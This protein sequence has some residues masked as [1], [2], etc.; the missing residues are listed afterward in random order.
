MAISI[1]STPSWKVAA[2]AA[3]TN[4]DCASCAALSVPVARPLAGRQPGA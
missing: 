4:L 1:W 2:G 3:V